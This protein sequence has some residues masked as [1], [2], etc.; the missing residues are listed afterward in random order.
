MKSP[1][2]AAPS[3]AFLLLAALLLTPRAHAQPP[4]TGGPWFRPACTGLTA[5]TAAGLAA[6]WDQTLNGLYG[7]D[8][9]SWQST[10]ALSTKVLNVKDPRFGAK[11][12]GVT[13]DTAAFT[14]AVSALPSTGGT[15]Y[16]PASATEYLLKN[17]TISTSNVTI[18]GA[19][20]GHIGALGPTIL[21]ATNGVIG[22]DDVVRCSGVAV[23]NV[24]L[25][26][27]QVRALG[28]NGVD[29]P[30]TAVASNCTGF[31]IQHVTLNDAGSNYAFDNV[32]GGVVADSSDSGGIFDSAIRG[33]IRIKSASFRLERTY[34]NGN[35][36]FATAVKVES[37]SAGASAV[38]VTIANN[39]F[40]SYLGPIIDVGNA[41]LAVVVSPVIAFNKIGSGSVTANVVTLGDATNGVENAVLIGNKIDGSGGSATRGIT[42]NK[43][44]GI[45]ATGNDV[46]GPFSAGTGAAF[47]LVGTSTAV[48]I[49]ANG[50]AAVE[51][52]AGVKYTGSVYHGTDTAQL[53]VGPGVQVGGPTGADRG[54]GTLNVAS[55][56]LMNGVVAL[57]ST[58]TPT[59]LSG[60]GNTPSVTGTD[61]AMRVTVST[62]V[63]TTFLVNFGTAWAGAPACIAQQDGARPQTATVAHVNT[64]STGVTL[65]TL[66]APANGNVY[67]VL[68][69]GVTAG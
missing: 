46:S 47:V 13:D 43:A 38:S 36:T 28:P 5:P 37:P 51:T 8:G 35:N 63:T 30:G 48:S 24:V 56:V 32:V 31:R 33:N 68:C 64:T 23:K 66:T 27:L 3:A 26:D 52:S 29:K 15:I 67:T 6:C 44:A 55:S 1:K 57:K 2:G 60:C 12:D 7:F 62:N 4:T 14:A 19:G 40:D 21:R 10:G 34:F 11:G 65:N 18:Q 25:K 17:F 53:V 42:I 22:T 45:L 59:C 69:Q 49:V 50:D 54:V 39:T 9:T 16:V 41:A 20:D 61:S 58:G